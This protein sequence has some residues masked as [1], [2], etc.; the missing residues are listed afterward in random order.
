MTDTTKDDVTL[1]Q[2]KPE[3]LPS[4]LRT[5]T[6]VPILDQQSLIP[7]AIKQR[8]LV[9]QPTQPGDLYYGKDGNS[10]TN[11]SIGDDNQI[12][13]ASGGVPVW[14]NLNMTSWTP[15]YGASGSMTFTS[16]TTNFA[17]YVII[18]SICYYMIYASGTTG[19]V[20][21]T[22]ITF[23]TPR[24]IVSG[25]YTGAYVRTGATGGIAGMVYPSSS[26][27]ITVRK[28]DSSNWSLDASAAFGVTGFFTI[29]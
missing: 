24:T 23:T 25:G 6:A 29:A 9:P 19:G 27:V 21:S 7:G 28:Y 26:T 18:G 22:D 8:H 13:M 17:L 4:S 5:D 10:F 14:S 16:V 1:K 2:S 11:L 12:L 3:K 20:T 15:T